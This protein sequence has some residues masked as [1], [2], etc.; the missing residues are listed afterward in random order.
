MH[1]RGTFL[2]PGR[3][4]GAAVLSA[5]L[6]VGGADVSLAISCGHGHLRHQNDMMEN[7]ALRVLLQVLCV[8]ERV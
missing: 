4:P 2:C 1:V 8:G 6:G 5:A 7:C 3:L